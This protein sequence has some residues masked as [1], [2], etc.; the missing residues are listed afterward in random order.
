ME[1]LFGGLRIAITTAAVA[2]AAFASAV[3]S[4]A[5]PTAAAVA[6]AAFA[7]AVASAAGPAPSVRRNRQIDRFA[8]GR[9]NVVTHS[10]AADH[11]PHSLA[12]G[13]TYLDH[14]LADGVTDRQPHSLAD[15]V[16]DHQPH[17]LA[18]GVTYLDHSLANVCSF[19]PAVCLALELTFLGSVEPA[20]HCSVLGAPPLAACLY[21]NLLRPGCRVVR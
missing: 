10:L 21:L 6:A 3:A 16:T 13:V 7:S 19:E 1:H 15:G 14:S 12:D 17:S 5:G 4:A 9:T 2:A 18:D 20:F 8:N 11:Q